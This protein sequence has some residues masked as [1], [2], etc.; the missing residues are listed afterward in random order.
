MDSLIL[1]EAKLTV[2]PFKNSIK[3]NQPKR[4]N[5]TAES[6][7]IQGTQDKENTDL[8]RS[9]VPV[10]GEVSDSDDDLALTAHDSK[11]QAVKRLPFSNSQVKHNALVVTQS[12]GN[13][14]KP[15]YDPISNQKLRKAAADRHDKLRSDYASHQSVVYGD[16]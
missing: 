16:M 11:R 6:S 2:S 12:K 1:L 15:R 7:R 13:I 3:H 5:Q 10:R 9:L 14:R 4:Q 8:Q